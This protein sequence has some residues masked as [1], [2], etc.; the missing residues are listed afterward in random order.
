MEDN[1][2]NDR[3]WLKGVKSKGEVAEAYGITTQ[4]LRTWLLKFD[5]YQRFPECLSS[6]VFTPKQLKAII[7][8]LGEP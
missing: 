5:F 4:T 2:Y 1:Y 6:Q 3:T 8:H 7:D